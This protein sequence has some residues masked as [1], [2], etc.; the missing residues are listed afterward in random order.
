MEVNKETTRGD[1]KRLGDPLLEV[2]K[3][4]TMTQQNKRKYKSSNIKLI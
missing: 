4:E 2:F 3:H 1:F